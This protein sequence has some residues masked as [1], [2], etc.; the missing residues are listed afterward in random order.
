MNT[1]PSEHI[2]YYD[3]DPVYRLT[4]AT[5]TGMI[6]ATYAYVYDPAGNMTVFTETVGV[7]TTWRPG[8]SGG[9]SIFDAIIR[10]RQFD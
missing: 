1:T 9:K 2:I 7:T 5:Y 8:Q 6:T 3:Y 10:K 4:G